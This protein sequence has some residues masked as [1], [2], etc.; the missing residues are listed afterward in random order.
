MNIRTETKDGAA[1]VRIDGEVDMLESPKLRGVLMRLVDEET[2]VIAVDLKGV[3]FMD[4]AGIATLVECY[5]GVKR[6]EGAF[7]LL[8]PNKRVRGAIS[9]ARLDRVFEIV[10]DESGL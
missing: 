4:S 6:Y 10:D 5:Q 8:A 2:P 7:K 1:I 3:D 9:L